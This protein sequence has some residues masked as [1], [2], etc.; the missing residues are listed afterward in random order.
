MAGVV[1]NTV[2]ERESFT[3]EVPGMLEITDHSGDTV[4]DRLNMLL[5]Q[6]S[7]RIGKASLAWIGS[8]W[9]LIIV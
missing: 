4:T 7:S 9:V 5:K 6:G 8:K 1:E 2:V 3:V